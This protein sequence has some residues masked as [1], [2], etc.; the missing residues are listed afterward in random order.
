M[1]YLLLTNIGSLLRG[2]IGS[3]KVL[4]TDDKWFGV[5]YQE[6]KAAVVESIRG[7]IESGVYAEDLYSDLR[8]RCTLAGTVRIN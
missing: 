2:E 3:V 4:E 7:L 5:T 8:D 1:Q 6:D